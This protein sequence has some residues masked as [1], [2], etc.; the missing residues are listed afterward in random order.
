LGG[1]SIGRKINRSRRT[2]HSLILPGSKAIPGGRNVREG[3]QFYPLSLLV[4]CRWPV[5]DR[6]IIKKCRFRIF[7]VAGKYFPSF[8]RIDFEEFCL[9]RYCWFDLV[10]FRALPGLIL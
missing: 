1:P 3:V 10:V 9:I 2:R 5:V 6:R 8:A 4:C 7:C